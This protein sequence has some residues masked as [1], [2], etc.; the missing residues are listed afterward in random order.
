MT[1][2]LKGENTTEEIEARDIE[3]IVEQH[4]NQFVIK[5]RHRD[6]IENTHYASEELPLESIFEEE[7]SLNHCCIYTLTQSRVDPNNSR[8]AVVGSNGWKRLQEEAKAM[9]FHSKVKQNF[10]SFNHVLFS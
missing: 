7:P 4:L 9:F 8:Q 3:Q 1:D 10:N 2:L 6:A 5:A